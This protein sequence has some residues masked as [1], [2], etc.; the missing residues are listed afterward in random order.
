[1][2]FGFKFSG[3]GSKLVHFG[4]KINKLIKKNYSL[5]RKLRNKAKTLAKRSILVPRGG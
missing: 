4:I 2:H 1:M 5:S 3:L